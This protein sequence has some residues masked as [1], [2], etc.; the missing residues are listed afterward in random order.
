VPEIGCSSL[1]H[2]N[3][4]SFIFGKKYGKVGL[5]GQSSQGRIKRGEKSL[6]K[7]INIIIMILI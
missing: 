1:S 7:L 2:F 4:Y 3:L 6:D 5:S